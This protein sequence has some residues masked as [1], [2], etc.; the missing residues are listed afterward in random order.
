MGAVYSSFRMLMILQDGHCIGK[1]SLCVASTPEASSQM[2]KFDTVKTI[3]KEQNDEYRSEKVT[4]FEKSILTVM[5]DLIFQ[6]ESTQSGPHWKHHLLGKI[7]FKATMPSLWTCLAILCVYTTCY[8]IYI[9]FYV[10][11]QHHQ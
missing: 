10:I 3:W 2:W 11:F 8:M 4:S 6:L 5:K 7:T 9:V 1:V